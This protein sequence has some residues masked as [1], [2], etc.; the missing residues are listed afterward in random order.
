MARKEPPATCYTCGAD[1]PDTPRFGNEATCDDCARTGRYTVER[2]TPRV[3][4][5][6]AID[7]AAEG[8]LTVE[9]IPIEEF[10]K[11]FP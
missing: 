3:M 2:I 10:R 11:R 1:V 5:G 6:L 8:I 4:S 7:M 9:T